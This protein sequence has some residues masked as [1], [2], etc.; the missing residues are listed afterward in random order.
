MNIKPKMVIKKGSSFVYDPATFAQYVRPHF[1][2]VK[3]AAEIIE[4]FGDAKMLVMDTECRPLMQDSRTLDKSHVRRWIGTGAKA[5]PVDIPFCISIGDGVTFA[6]LYDYDFEAK[7]PELQKLK[8]FLSNK[9]LE[10][11]WH[12]AKFDQHMLANIG[13]TLGGKVHDTVLLTKLVNENRPAF[14][15]RSVSQPYNGIEDFEFMVDLYKKMHKITDYSKIPR[16]LITQYANADIFNCWQVFNAEYS[17][18]AEQDLQDL[19]E[20]ELVV[21]KIAYDMERAG[22]HANVEYEQALYADLLKAKDEAEAAVYDMAGEIFNMNSSS[23]LHKVMLKLGVP[24]NAFAYSD[25]G[26]VKLDKFEMDKF[27]KRGVEIVSKVLAFKQSDKL[28]T[29]YAKGIY[30]QADAS[31]DVHCGINTGEATTGRMSVTKPA[32]Q[33]LPK[34]NKS[35][36]KIFEPRP[37]YRM[38]TFDLDQVEYRLYA[39]YSQDTNLC[40]LIKDGY[41][42][43]TACAALLFNVPITEVKEDQRSKAK[44]IN[45]GLLYGQGAAALAESLN[46]TATE[47]QNM[48]SNYFK[49]LP[50]SRGFIDNVQKV[51]RQ[52]GYIRNFYKRRRRLTSNEC[53]KAVNALIQGVAADYIKHKSANIYKFLKM[54]NYKTRMLLWVHDE[55]IFEIHESEIHLVPIIRWLMSDFTTFRTY[56]TAGVEECAPNWGSKIDLGTETGFKELSVDEV[57]A[58]KNYNVW[59]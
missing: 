34:K 43:H 23:Q 39:H 5:S 11:I 53:Y 4:L 6:T 52:R 29:T 19:Y 8:D 50:T 13:L 56:I 28:L 9:E 2:E 20:N 45:F 44:T 25:K 55:I 42:V 41:D 30:S 10:T 12:N 24:E 59:Q 38:F 16:E 21:S 35:I 1:I 3:S 47:A 26:N 33:T 54:N 31:N 48:K 49:G 58:I 40:Q 27:E 17:Q 36:R 15:L 57:E 32:L 14:T 46:M 7:C 51:T 22:M 18:L 37:G